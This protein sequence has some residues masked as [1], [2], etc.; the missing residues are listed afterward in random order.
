MCAPSFLGL[1]VTEAQKS[2]QEQHT[3]QQF[4]RI[5]FD[6]CQNKSSLRTAS[7][8]M[9]KETLDTENVRVI[10]LQPCIQSEW[11]IC[12]A[13]QSLETSRYNCKGITTLA[14]TSVIFAS[15]GY[16]PERC[17]D[18]VRTYQ[19]IV[20]RIVRRRVSRLPSDS[21]LSLPFP[22]MRTHWY[23]YFVLISASFCGMTGQRLSP[24]CGCFLAAAEIEA[25]SFGCTPNP[26][27][28]VCKRD[29]TCTCGPV[30]S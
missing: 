8:A 28:Y 20:R 12:D 6:T 21:V 9:I 4:R 26:L 14:W 27:S 16:A 3:T 1:Q 24:A 30:P 18:C 11:I 15:S 25:T 19:G 29:T 13:L 22:A 2:S 23:R 7:L 10:I 5:R 17:N